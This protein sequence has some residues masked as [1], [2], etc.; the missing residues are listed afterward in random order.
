MK[1]SPHFRFLAWRYDEL[2][3]LGI[4]GPKPSVPLGNLS[5]VF[6]LVSLYLLQN[7]FDV[8][9]TYENIILFMLRSKYLYKEL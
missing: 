7:A 4:P 6:K 2:K 8:F 5:E 9:M 1:E 3:N